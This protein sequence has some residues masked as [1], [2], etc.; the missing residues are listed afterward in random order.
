M[1]LEAIDKV[2]VTAKKYG[3][4]AG[5]TAADGEAAK[6]MKERFDLV[7]MRGDVKSLRAWYSRELKIARS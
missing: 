3:K 4:K 1:F 5:I 2:V 7:L 6:K